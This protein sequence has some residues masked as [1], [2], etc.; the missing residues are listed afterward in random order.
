MKFDLGYWWP[1]ARTAWGWIVASA[2]ILA[3]FYYF[4]KKM[5]ETFDWYMNRFRDYKVR[6]FLE[7]LVIISPLA[8]E[9][10]HTRAEVKSVQQIASATRLSEKR[11]KGCLRRL[12]EKRIVKTSGQDGWR[13]NVSS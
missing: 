12:R 2:T 8:N 7:S 13:A 5:L 11:V 6:D 4:P 9:Q 3:G 10:A 1:F